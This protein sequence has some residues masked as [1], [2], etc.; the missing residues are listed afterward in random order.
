[1]LPQIPLLHHLN[2]VNLKGYYTKLS[3]FKFP[4]KI[5][6]L[7]WEWARNLFKVGKKFL[8][9]RTAVYLHWRWRHHSLNKTWSHKRAWVSQRTSNSISTQT[10][11]VKKGF[12]GRNYYD[13]VGRWLCYFLFSADITKQH[14]APALLDSIPL[15]CRMCTTHQS[16]EKFYPRR[17]WKM[18]SNLCGLGGGGR[19]PN[20]TSPTL[21]AAWGPAATN[22]RCS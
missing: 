13:I 15:N 22:F 4:T 21:A 17:W 8:H 6:Q 16:Q 11:V 5:N 20:L 2:P 1:M 14:K 12:L 3:W 7:T 19:S 10:W 9:S 18:T